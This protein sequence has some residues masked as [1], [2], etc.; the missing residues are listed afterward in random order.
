M[1]NDPLISIITICYNASEDVQKTLDNVL[2]QTYGNIEHI[3]IDGGSSDGTTEI[4]KKYESQINNSLKRFSWISEKDKGI[5]DAFN[6]GISE[7]TG[8]WVIFLNAGDVFHD[9]N[10]LKNVSSQL[11][12]NS[13][14]DIVHGKIQMVNGSKKLRI[15]GNAINKMQLKHH[16]NL[17]HQATFHKADFWKKYG[18][19]SLDFKICMDYELILRGLDSI[20]F[21]FVDLLIADMD[22]N[23]VSQTRIIDLYREHRIAQI[24]NK[25][26]PKI[27]AYWFNFTNIISFYIKYVVKKVVY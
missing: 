1:K 15:H 10:V 16:M 4:L 23:G 9:S 20:K 8:D 25:T 17:P 12:L 2:E 22:A 18:N 14:S 6:K 13:D 24:K 3:I 7:V 11:L 26:T 27:L 19:Y 21:H 5:S